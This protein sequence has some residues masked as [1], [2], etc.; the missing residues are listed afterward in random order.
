MVSDQEKRQQKLRLV[1][2]LISDPAVLMTPHEACTAVRFSIK[3]YC[4]NDYPAAYLEQ[5]DKAHRDLM[6]LTKM[7]AM[8]NAIHYQH[9]L[10]ICDS[11]RDINA[12]ID[13]KVSAI[14]VR[15]VWDRKIGNVR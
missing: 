7:K 6:V 10:E 8:T 13:G 12:L 11:M 15:E 9:W 14:P 4:S 3:D 1:L 2:E 5:R